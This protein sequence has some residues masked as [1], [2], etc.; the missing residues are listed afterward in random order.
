MTQRS[1]EIHKE[2]RHYR[3][4]AFADFMDLVYMRMP[5][6]DRVLLPR[7]T[8]EYINALVVF[9]LEHLRDFSEAIAEMVAGVYTQSPG[10]ER[11]ILDPT[12]RNEI[13]ESTLF[14]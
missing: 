2:V 14:L 1:T 8:G 11:F 12:R 9:A 5:E 6:A 10:G 4:P 3:P 13:T 7:E